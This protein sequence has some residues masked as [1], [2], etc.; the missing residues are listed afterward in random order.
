LLKSGGADDGQRIGI[1]RGKTSAMPGDPTTECETVPATCAGNGAQTRTADGSEPPTANATPCASARH[2]PTLIEPAISSNIRK[3]QVRAALF[4]KLEPVRVGRFILLERLGAGT[5]GDIY[6]AYDEQL[7]RRLALKIVRHGASLTVKG[8]ALL[9]REAQALAQVSHPNVVQ[10]YDAGTHDGRLFIAMELV[11]GQTLT[12][13][14]ESVARLPRAQRQREILQQFIAAGRGLEAAHAVG[15][16]H[17]DF[18]PDNVLVG[19]DGRVRVVDFGLARAVIEDSGPAAS[20]TPGNDGDPPATDRARGGTAP[21]GLTASQVN[22]TTVSMAL[23]NRD[24]T[25]DHDRGGRQAMA[26]NSSAQAS[27]PGQVEVAAGQ[28]EVAAGQVEVAATSGEASNAPKLTAAT[29]LTAT[30]TV[31]GTPRFMAPEQIQGLVADHRSDQ[32][33]FCVALYQALYEV[34]PFAGD[35]MQGFLNSMQTG[36][37]GLEH[38]AGVDARVRSALRRGLSVDR[39]Q[40]FQNM[41]ELL[42]ALERSLRRRSGWAAGVVFFCFVVIVVYSASSSSPDARC[43]ATGDAIR[44]RWSADRQAIVHATFLRSDLPYAEAVWRSF[45][46]RLDIYASQWREQAIA[47]CRATNVDHVQSQRQFDLRMLC[48]DRSRREADALLRELDGTPRA[49]QRA[50]AASELLPDV[51][52]CSHTESIMFGLEP[53]PESIAAEV[54]RVRE[55]LAQ[56]L[57]LEWLGRHEESLVIARAAGAAAEPLAYPPLRAEALTQIARALDARD[58]AT[59][60]AEAQSLYFTALDIAE[61]HRH[62][63]LAVSVWGRLVL[64]ATRMDAGTERAHERWRRYEAAVTRIGNNPHDRARLH[65]ML[66]QIYLRESRYAEAAEQENLAIKEI[67]AAPEQKLELS[68][69]YD[70]LANALQPQGRGDEAIVLHERA[71]AIASESLGQAHP[72][73]IK[74]QMN[75]GKALEKLGRLE[76]ARTVLEAA[77]ASMPAK[78]RDSRLDAGRLHAFLSDL[79]YVEGKLDDAAGHGLESLRIYIR[80]GGPDHLR[81]EARTNLGNVEL[82]RKNFAGA[83]AM[84]REALALRR[85][86]L[87]NDDDQLGVNEG[88]IAEALVGL[89]RYD[90]AMLHVREAE[91]ILARSSARDRATQAWICTV[92]GDVLVGQQRFAAAIPMLEQAVPLF[93]NTSDPDAPRA[94][95]L[96]A[97]ALH[98]AGKDAG[99]VRLLAERARALFLK[100]GPAEAQRAAAIGRFI[101]R[102]EPATRAPIP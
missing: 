12:R 85:P 18:K 25:L 66:G 102:L 54:A 97:R 87:G 32:F 47:A 53:P 44:D 33:S 36:A 15:V 17:R 7:D 94:M 16:A 81:A 99:R 101:Q 39:S 41:G 38:G 93:D 61:A 6:A 64:L 50:V 8:D 70:A 77:L 88:S 1:S 60:R 23:A 34:F 98:G 90:E 9:Q 48:L 45:A 13:W 40:R 91:S 92:H 10:V 35:G 79:S 57:A 68:R 86:H 100:L 59:S 21:R 76:R 24:D 89:A 19:D 84:Y 83:L 30:G 58:N 4:G 43:A 49:V 73:L 28:V 46:Q 31:M 52:S 71:V 56:A 55:Q 62:D 51:Q 80:A 75:Y 5:M 42:A 22:S 3:A 96:L 82:R 95:W 26:L 11:R 37:I 74:L 67:A 72:D 27:A 78:Y 29:K 2:A 65:H 69:Y 63:Q 14:L 20:V